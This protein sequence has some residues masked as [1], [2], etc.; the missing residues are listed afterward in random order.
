MN[1]YVVEYHGPFG[2]IKPWTAVRDGITFSQ[3]F[4]TPSIVEGMRLLLGV[5]QI[6]RHRLSYSGLSDQQERIQAPGWKTTKTKGQKGWMTAVRNQS[7]LNRNVLIEPHLH[8][9]F[10][11]EAEANVAARHHICLC[12]NEDIVYPIGM[13][14]MTEEEFNKI[15]GFELLFGN[16]LTSNFLVGYNRYEDAAPMYGSLQVV[17]NASMREQL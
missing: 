15:D 17:G 14:Q 11:T 7:I 1:Y 4:L 3:Q 13:Q 5:D 12:R 2:Y 9:A 8:L 6:L 16:D 10:A